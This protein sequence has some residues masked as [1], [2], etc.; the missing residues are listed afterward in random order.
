MKVKSDQQQLVIITTLLLF[1]GPCE[2]WISN[3]RLYYKNI[4]LI[5]ILIFID[6]PERPKTVWT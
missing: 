6:L 2:M 4:F 5:A 3:E 1:S